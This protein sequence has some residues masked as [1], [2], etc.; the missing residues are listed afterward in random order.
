MRNTFLLYFKE[1]LKSFNFLLLSFDTEFCKKFSRSRSGKRINSIIPLIVSSLY[2]LY[3]ENYLVDYFLPL[4]FLTKL[5]SWLLLF[6]LLLWKKNS[7]N[8][9]LI[10]ENIYKI[11]FKKILDRKEGMWKERFFSTG[12]NAPVTVFK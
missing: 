12:F 1:L 9:S 5:L 4:E 3:F 2:T 6:L 11:V 10:E 8:V 7:F